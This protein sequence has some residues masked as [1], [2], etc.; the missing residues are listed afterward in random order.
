MKITIT[1]PRETYNKLEKDRG[2]I[3][4]S[5]YI[6][7]LVRGVRNS[8]VDIEFKSK[9]PEVRDAMVFAKAVLEEDEEPKE[10]TS[11]VKAHKEFLGESKEKVLKDLESSGVV[12][13]GFSK[14]D[15]LSWKHRKNM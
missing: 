15:Q 1:L 8:Q 12:S 10:D 4:R 3:P 7:D 13:K 6:Q 5:T 2:S 11:H 9:D 14:A